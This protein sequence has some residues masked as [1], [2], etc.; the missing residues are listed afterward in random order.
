MFCAGPKFL[1]TPTAYSFFFISLS[2]Q[3]LCTFASLDHLEH[4]LCARARLESGRVLQSRTHKLPLIWLHTPKLEPHAVNAVNSA[5]GGL[6]GAVLGN[7]QR[8]L[9]FLGTPSTQQSS[10]GQGIKRKRRRRA[11]GPRLYFVHVPM[12]GS[13]TN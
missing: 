7:G 12:P 2:E 11:A 10:S 1:H 9:G 13:R 5:L 6:L 4:L 3:F 8:K